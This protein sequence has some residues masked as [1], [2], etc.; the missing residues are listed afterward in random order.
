MCSVDKYGAKGDGKNDDTA[1][2]QKSLD[3]C[4]GSGGG[5]VVLPASTKGIYLSKALSMSKD[6][7]HVE[8]NLPA[9]TVLR[10]NNDRKN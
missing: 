3:D 10:I 8:L 2:I 1:A 4:G 5:R 7:G 6:H 9:K